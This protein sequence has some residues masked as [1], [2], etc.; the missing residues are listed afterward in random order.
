MHIV[1]NSFNNTGKIVHKIMQ[2]AHFCVI[3][4]VKHKKL[5]FLVV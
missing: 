3:L 1:S 4:H 5:P 2:N